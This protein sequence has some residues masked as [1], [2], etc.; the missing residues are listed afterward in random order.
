MAPLP[1]RAPLVL[2]GFSLTPPFGPILAPSY[3]SVTLLSRRPGSYTR[4]LYGGMDGD[5]HYVRVRPPFK[6]RPRGHAARMQRQLSLA[7]K[8]HVSTVELYIVRPRE[9]HKIN[10]DRPTD[11]RKAL[12]ESGICELLGHGTSQPT[13]AIH[14]DAKNTALSK[15]TVTGQDLRPCEQSRGCIWWLTRD[16]A[17]SEKGSAEA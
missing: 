8:G 9:R 16:G 15:L 10:A 3:P 4:G 17:W 2:T 5:V 12:R 7:V 13:Q 14:S 1:Q 6:L 11:A